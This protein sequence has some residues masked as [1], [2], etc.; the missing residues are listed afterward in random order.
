MFQILVYIIFFASAIILY[1]QPLKSP[2]E[3]MQILNQ[4]SN[5]Y[6]IIGFSIANHQQQNKPLLSNNWSLFQSSDERFVTLDFRDVLESDSIMKIYYEIA[7][8]HFRNKMY[9]ESIEKY[10]Y[11][12][13]AY[14]HISQ[15]MTY[16]GHCYSLLNLNDSA[17]YWYRESIRINYYDYLA[18]WF[19]SDTYFKRGNIKSAVYEILLAHILN[20]N[21]L[22][23]IKTLNKYLNSIN[24]RFNADYIRKP[25]KLHKQNDSLI[26][27]YFDFDEHPA[28]MSYLLYKALWTYE[29]GYREK[30]SEQSNFPAL[31]EEKECV[32]QMLS[33]YFNIHNS[34]QDSDGNL[35]VKNN[36]IIT[37]IIDASKSG[38]L[39][40]LL[41][42]D[43]VLP[44]HPELVYQLNQEFF[45]RI[46]NYIWKFRIT[47]Q[48]TALH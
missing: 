39:N 23:V 18:H 13:Q 16:I 43:F 25:I 26:I 1:C 48:L 9:R 46:C 31:L 34:L 42:Y 4:S 24:Y 32:L 33:S 17:I 20:R 5:V 15:I 47:Q 14:P 19:L 35:K 40:E 3:L 45:E 8:E 27:C 11:I 10:T 21:D 12:L 30:M 7:Q 36:D 41:V 37:G 44:E 6:K 22:R 29:S 28:W 2:S 38:Y